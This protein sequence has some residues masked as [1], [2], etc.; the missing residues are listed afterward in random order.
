EASIRCASL[1]A[2]SRGYDF[3]SRSRLRIST[4]QCGGERKVLPD[5]RF[6]NADWKFQNV[7]LRLTQ[8]PLQQ[9]PIKIR[10]LPFCVAEKGTL[11][12]D[13]R[14]LGWHHFIPALVAAGDA[15]EHVTRKDRQIFRVEIIQLHEAA[16]AYQII[17]ERLQLGIHLER[18]N[19]L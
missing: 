8:P 12:N 11:A 15:L 14:H 9:R 13:L 6:Q 10:L 4:S 1:A 3:T 16:A 2:T 5:R 7:G 17:I 19:G 18:M